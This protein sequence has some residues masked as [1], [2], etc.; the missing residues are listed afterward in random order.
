MVVEPDLRGLRAWGVAGTAVVGLGLLMASMGRLRLELER[1]IVRR[2]QAEASLRE[3]NASLEVRVKDRTAELEEIVSD[4]DSFNR[5]V[6]HDLRGPLGV[7][8]A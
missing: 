4:L 8:E 5:M 6:S 1:E 2:C 7:S 3:V